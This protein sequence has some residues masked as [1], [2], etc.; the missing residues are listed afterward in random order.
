[1]NAWFDNERGVLRLLNG[2]RAIDLV[3]SYLDGVAL[4]RLSDAMYLV[5]DRALC[6]GDRVEFL[7]THGITATPYPWTGRGE[8]VIDH[9]DSTGV[10]P[11]F[12]V[13]RRDE[14]A[15]LDALKP[16]NFLPRVRDELNDSVIYSVN[17][18]FAALEDAVRVQGIK[19]VDAATGRAASGE[20][21]LAADYK[22]REANLPRREVH[23][24]DPEAA[25]IRDAISG[26]LRCPQQFDFSHGEAYALVREHLA[27][28][29]PA[30]YERRVAEG[31]MSKLLQYGP[32]EQS[33]LL[34]DFAERVPTHPTPGPDSAVARFIG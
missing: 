8:L 33:A 21:F 10:L 30:S 25:L 16:W 34:D 5:P 20:D 17:A 32:D 23:L 13:A 19:V 4:E 6:E 27:E 26:T 1:M 14:F 12:A 29:A 7:R 28:E 9:Y 22:R 15:V 18:P 24:T 31:L 11:A 2:Q 3:E